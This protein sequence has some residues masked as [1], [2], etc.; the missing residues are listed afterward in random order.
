VGR[1][2]RSGSTALEIAASSLPVL[3]L[4]SERVPEKVH[5]VACYD[6]SPG[7]RRGLLAGIE[8]ARARM[9]GITLLVDSGSEADPF[10]VETRSA[11]ADVE[12]RIRY[13]RFD[14]AH[15]AKLLATLKAEKGGILILGSRE[16]LSRLPPLDTLLRE[17]GMPLLLL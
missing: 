5:P 6:G 10:L 17:T 14:E 15:E 9:D 11:N 4:P 12:F 2:L 7:A 3:L 1:R 13:L 16:L 8:L